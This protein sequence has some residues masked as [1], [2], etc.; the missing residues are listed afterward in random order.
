M[1]KYR[2]KCAPSLVA[3]LLVPFAPPFSPLDSLSPCPFPQ[4]TTKVIII[5]IIETS[6]KEA[7]RNGIQN[8]RHWL[9][10]SRDP[11]P[12]V[13]AH[14]TLLQPPVPPPLCSGYGAFHP[15]K[16]VSRQFVAT[17]LLNG[18]TISAFFMFWYSKGTSQE[19]AGSRTG[20]GG[21][22]QYKNRKRKKESCPEAGRCRRAYIWLS[23]LL[24]VGS[25]GSSCRSHWH[26]CCWARS[27]SRS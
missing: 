5:I 13:S 17:L 11:P 21:A 18:V 14:T 20:R 16:Q 27:R 19:R 22:E 10:Q 12:G 8:H 24:E 25:L 23:Q 15:R 26:S 6:L 9:G 4:A 1:E 3:S 7:H 2:C